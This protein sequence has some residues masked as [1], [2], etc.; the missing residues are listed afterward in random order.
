[1]LVEIGSVDDPRIAAFAGIRDSEHRRIHG[2]FVA[3]GALVVARALRAGYRPVSVLVDDPAALASLP[4]LGATP[5]YVVTGDLLTRVT[6]LGVSRGIVGCFERRP[7]PTADEVVAGAARVVVLEGVVNPTNLGIIART[8]AA[9]GWEGLLL[10]ADCADP[11][12]RR[13]ARVSM[14]EVFALPYADVD[15]LPS[16]LEV[17][18]RQGFST[19]A[20]TPDPAAP[21]I[22]RFAPP[23]RLALVFGT[24]GPGLSDATTAAVDAL[25]RIPMHRGVDSLNVAAAAAIAC[26]ALSAPDARG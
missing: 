9:L 2:T 23:D 7:V 10:D 14:G 13:A 17:L 18:A 5:V 4:D 15:R 3:E 20:L 24:E 19:V 21:P 12:Y 26:Y 16:G 22:D 6:R 1:V 8:A 11:L 25:V